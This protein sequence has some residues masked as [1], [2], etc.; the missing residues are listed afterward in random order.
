MSRSPCPAVFLS[1]NL[2]ICNDVAHIL[3]TV[4]ER[5]MTT[6]SVLEICGPIC[7]DSADGVKIH[8]LVRGALSQ[9][10]SVCLDFRNVATLA[11]A[12]LGP[13]VGNLYAEFC[14]ED[15][16]ARLHLTGLDTIDE[17]ILKVVQRKAQQFY[18]ADKV[19]QQALLSSTAD[20]W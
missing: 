10:E 19:Q 14:K 1:F 11:S 6:V 4:R 13:A 8:D 20:Q 2:L 12:F 18:A 3:P 17:S 16:E 5:V 9:G 15:L 7:I